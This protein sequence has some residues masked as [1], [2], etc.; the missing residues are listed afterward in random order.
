[1][2]EGEEG[3]DGVDLDLAAVVG[4]GELGGPGGE[5]GE[6]DGLQRLILIFEK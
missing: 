1:M 5:V 6:G 3:F 2:G 4:T